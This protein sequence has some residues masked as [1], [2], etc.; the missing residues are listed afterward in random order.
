[1]WKRNDG[2]GQPAAAVEG[3]SKIQNPT[4]HINFN[5]D[6]AD[7]FYCPHTSTSTPTKFD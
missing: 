6:P 2:G 7:D 1:M 4:S 5:L 3:S